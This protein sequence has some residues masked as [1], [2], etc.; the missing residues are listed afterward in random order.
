MT[1]GEKLSGALLRMIRVNFHIDVGRAA[2]KACSATW[3]GCTNSEFA[4]GS[5]KSREMLIDLVDSYTF[6]MKTTRVRVRITLRL[7]VNCQSVRLGKSFNTHDQYFFFNCT[8][9]FIVLM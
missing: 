8:L 3:N 4:L 1:R 6:Q 2:C 7:E 5:R 9:A